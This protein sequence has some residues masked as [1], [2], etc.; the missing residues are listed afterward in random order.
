MEITAII[1][2]PC[3]KRRSLNVLSNA[4][5]SPSHRQVGAR[6]IKIQL[7]LR[8]APDLS[9][10]ISLAVLFGSND[11]SYTASMQSDICVYIHIYTYT[12]TDTHTHTHT[13]THTFFR[14]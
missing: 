13:H 2:T 5:Y 14:I 4:T 9:T 8:T 7:T 12:H 6:M 3:S 11:N 1:T 10:H